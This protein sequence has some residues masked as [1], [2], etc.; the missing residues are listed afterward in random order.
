MANITPAKISK[1]FIFVNL[2]F[3]LKAP[4]LY[5]LKMCS[6][7]TWSWIFMC[8]NC[9]Q[10]QCKPRNDAMQCHHL[11]KFKMFVFWAWIFLILCHKRK[12]VMRLSWCSWRPY[13]LRKNQTW[14]TKYLL[15]FVDKR[16]CTTRLWMMLW[17]QTQQHLVLWWFWDFHNKYIVA[18]VAIL[19]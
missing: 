2:C 17:T 12:S 13:I 1:Y 3:E 7:R 6:H 4:R 14:R 18:M 5:T 15:L 11:H 9:I 16:R 19:P 8:Q 10:S